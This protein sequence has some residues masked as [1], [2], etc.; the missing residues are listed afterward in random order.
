MI[1]EKK[2]KIFHQKTQKYGFF[3]SPC[4]GFNVKFHKVCLKI[5][6]IWIFFSTGLA[7]VRTQGNTFQYDRRP[8][9]V[10]YYNVDY[11]KDPKGKSLSSNDRSF[12]H[13]FF[14]ARTIGAT[15]SLR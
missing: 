2:L 14:Q 4:T 8:L 13:L 3:G 15:V 5:M 1:F 11:V 7:G 9:F 6:F 12:A 10:V